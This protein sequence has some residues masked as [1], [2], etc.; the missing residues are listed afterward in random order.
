M[1]LICGGGIT[2]K[3]F[4]SERYYS[5]PDLFSVLAFNHRNDSRIGQSCGQSDSPQA[6]STRH[7]KR[8]G[9]PDGQP[10]FLAPAREPRTNRRQSSFFALLA[11]TITATICGR[12]CG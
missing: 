11:N 7:H 10:G 2:W 12:K 8:P 6:P 4:L 9:N 3:A 5:K 1:R